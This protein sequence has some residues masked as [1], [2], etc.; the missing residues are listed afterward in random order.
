MLS[1]I[2]QLDEVKEHFSKTTEFLRNTC[3][4]CSY[5]IIDMN[6][7]VLSQC[8]PATE[9][10]DTSVATVTEAAPVQLNLTET[11]DRE[12]YN[13]QAPDNCRWCG[14]TD[15]WQGVDRKICR[16]CHPPAPGAE[17]HNSNKGEQ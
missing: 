7:S 10:T 8:E 14:S 5:S 11:V 3:N 6:I 16:S 9:D 4:N 17:R 12:S 13:N 15:F 2:F 1:E